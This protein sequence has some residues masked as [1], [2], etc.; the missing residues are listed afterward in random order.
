MSV[1]QC[2]KLQQSFRSFILFYLFF[3]FL[4]NSFRKENRKKTERERQ[5]N[6]EEV[7]NLSQVVK[8][9]ILLCHWVDFTLRTINRI[10]PEIERKHEVSRDESVCRLRYDTWKLFNEFNYSSSFFGDWR[11]LIS[12]FPPSSLLFPCFYDTENYSY[13]SEPCVELIID[14]CSGNTRIFKDIRKYS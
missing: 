11:N 8:I 5:R 7:N 3:C 1:I 4:D 10:I 6:G 12:T 9:L 14:T 2:N 13:L